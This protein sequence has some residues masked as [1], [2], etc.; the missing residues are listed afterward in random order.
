MSITALVYK[1]Q[2]SINAN[3]QQVNIWLI[4]VQ[5]FNYLVQL[6]FFVLTYKCTYSTKLV[7]KFQEYRWRY[8]AFNKMSYWYSIEIKRW[9]ILAT[10]CYTPHKRPRSAPIEATSEENKVSDVFENWRLAAVSGLCLLGDA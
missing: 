8:D 9:L 4:L 2:N 6:K 10:N 3:L 1:I 5:T 7:L